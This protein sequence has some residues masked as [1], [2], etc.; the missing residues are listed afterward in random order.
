MT[1]LGDRGQ[2]S[3]LA[4]VTEYLII[5]TGKELKRQI[6]LMGPQCASHYF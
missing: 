5:V 3:V 1:G 4:T 6:F 2:E